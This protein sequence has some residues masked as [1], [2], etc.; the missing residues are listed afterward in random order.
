[1]LA[2]AVGIAGV[3][4]TAAFLRPDPSGQGT[5]RQLGLPPCAYLVLTGQ[6]CPSCGLTTAFA[7]AVRGR[8]D[9]AWRAN[10]AGAWL[11]VC[12]AA[13]VPWMIASAMSG[14]PR[15]GARSIDGPLIFVI[16]A[17]VGLGLGAWTIRW[18]LGRVL[19]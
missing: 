9:R 18:I 15:L 2:A 4:V 3:Y 12:G 14:R 17:A 7:W 16:V 5:H 6:R 8:V 11:A 13:L 10:P 1:L 19:G